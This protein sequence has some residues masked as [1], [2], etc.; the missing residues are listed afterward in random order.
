MF[1]TITIDLIAQ[2]IGWIASIVAMASYFFKSIRTVRIVSLASCG[3]FLAYGIMIASVSVIVC[4][5]SI[6]II[7]VL[8]LVTAGNIGIVIRTNVRK[9]IAIFAIYT[10]AMVAL[11][12]D[13]IVTSAIPVIEA[14][15]TISG[16]GLAGAF[17]IPDERKMRAT[18]C[19]LS[20]CWIV[21]AASIASPQILV[22]NVVSMTAN[23][24]NLRMA[25]KTENKGTSAAS[26]AVV[27]R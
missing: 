22:T 4:N 12:W 24:M 18:C 1:E 15:G 17:L 5:V 21:Y 2:G 27:A 19:A 10:A 23:V 16:I 13:A 20:I 8:Y 11:S 6:A 3:I 9:V 7:H 26:A 25:R 14:I